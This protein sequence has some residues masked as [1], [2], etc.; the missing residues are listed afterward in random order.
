MPGYENNAKFQISSPVDAGK[1]R[2]AW[3]NI[4]V[5]WRSSPFIIISSSNNFLS[6]IFMQVQVIQG[7]SKLA[8]NMFI[9]EKGGAKGLLGFGIETENKDLQGLK[10]LYVILGGCLLF[11]NFCLCLK[12][13]ILFFGLWKA[14]F[15]F[16]NAWLMAL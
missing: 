14:L 8:S 13:F 6:P 10:N 12:N 11:Q 7:V 1:F 5:V 15:C 16:L 2:F 9:I 3:D 4:S